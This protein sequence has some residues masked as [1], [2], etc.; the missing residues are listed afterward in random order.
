MG[1]MSSYDIQSK[2]EDINVYINEK[3]KLAH[4]KNKRDWRT[5]EQQFS[6][7]VSTAMKMLDPLIHE[8]VSTIHIERAAG[9][10]YLLSLEDRVKLLLIKQFFAKSNRMFSNMLAMFSML[11]KIEVSYKTIERLYSDPEVM[12]AIHNLHILLLEKKG[13]TESN[14]TGDS[15]G[16]S[17]T[18]KK[19][20]ESY[21]QKLKDMAKVSVDKGQET[22]KHKRKLFAYMFAIMDLK[23]RM[24]INPDF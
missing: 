7:R 1:W 24:Y 12:L 2:L 9:H 10:P 17:L 13:I 8:A 14:I 23:T 20:Y 5:Y 22:K 15:T 18:V 3:Y 21:A 19:N 6:S 16:Y 4:P 11:S